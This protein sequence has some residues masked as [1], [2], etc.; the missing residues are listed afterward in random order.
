MVARFGFIEAKRGVWEVVKTSNG[1]WVQ[2]TDH[3]H[4]LAEKDRQLKDY[5]SASEADRRIGERQCD[6]LTDKLAEKDREIEKLRNSLQ[7]VL[8]HKSYMERELRGYGTPEE[9]SA[10]L[11]AFLKERNG[12]E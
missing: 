6:E 5:I 3:E 10:K 11:E 9:E 1:P 4:A 12:G 2:Y 7:K 8:V